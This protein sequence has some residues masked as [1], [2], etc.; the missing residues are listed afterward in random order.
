MPESS[1]G[2]ARRVVPNAGD[3]VWADEPACARAEQACFDPYLQVSARLTA[4]SQMGHATD[5]IE[6]IVLGGTWSDYPAEY[7][8]WFMRE[9]FRALLA[10]RGALSKHHVALHARSRFSSCD[11]GLSG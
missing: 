3:R 5:K 11:G 2:R 1:S 10:A 9:L 4:L 6:L 7:Q 8:I